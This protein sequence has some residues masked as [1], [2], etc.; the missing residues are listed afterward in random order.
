[1][2][3]V[4]CLFVL[5]LLL[6]VDREISAPA[7]D[8]VRRFLSPPKE[9]LGYNGNNNNN[10]AIFLHLLFVLKSLVLTLQQELL[11]SNNIPSFVMLIS[12]N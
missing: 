3:I 5:T 10:I 6:F 1:M 4:V 9:R 2:L 12:T 8:I 7:Q 11:R